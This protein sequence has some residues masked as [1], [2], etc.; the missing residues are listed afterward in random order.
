MDLRKVKADLSGF[1]RKSVTSIN[2]EVKEPSMLDR[3]R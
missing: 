3:I 2:M 1:D